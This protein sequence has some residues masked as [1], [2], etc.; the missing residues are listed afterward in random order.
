MPPGFAAPW[1]N[2]EA[3]EVNKSKGQFCTPP[4]SQG[5]KPDQVE[6]AFQVKHVPE[7]SKLFP[8]ASNFAWEF[9]SIFT[10]CGFTA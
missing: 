8:P 10:Q 3:W 2:K 9:F 7:A 1:N 6:G 4:S 5:E